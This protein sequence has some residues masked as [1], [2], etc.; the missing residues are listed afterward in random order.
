M[1]FFP[2]ASCLLLMSALSVSCLRTCAQAPCRVDEIRFT[3]VDYDSPCEGGNT[4]IDPVRNHIATGTFAWF[5]IGAPMPASAY[6]FQNQLYFSP[7][8]NED[9]GDYGV[10]FTADTTGCTDTAYAHLDSLVIA[11]YPVILWEEDLCGTVKMKAI[12]FNDT[13]AAHNNYVWLDQFGNYTINSQF[14]T[15]NRTTATV[16]ITNSYGCSEEY[17][18]YLPKSLLQPP[19]ADTVIII[20]GGPAIVC[21]GTQRTYTVAP[22][23]NV[24]YSWTVPAGVVIN[25]GQATPSIAVSFNSS[26]HGGFLK[27]KKTNQCGTTTYSKN[28]VQG[29]SPVRPGTISGIA[30]GLCGVVT[31]YSITNVTGMTY[32]WTLPTGATI[33]NGQGTQVIKVSFPATNFAGVISVTATTNCGTSLARTLSVKSVPGTPTTITG[34]TLVCNGSVGIVYSIAPITYATQYTWTGPTGSRIT[35]NGTTSAANVLT[36]ASPVISVNF[37]KVTTASSIKVQAGNGCGLGVV[38]TLV[39]T[40]CVPRLALSETATMQNILLYPNPI[41]TVTTLRLEMITSS[42]LHFEIMDLEG[43]VWIEKDETAIEGINAYP[44]DLTSLSAGVY[45]VKLKTDQ[46]QKMVRFVKE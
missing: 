2:L 12:N 34:L 10:I 39:L 22:E 15:T 5:R 18:D 1:K 16:K 33:V 32:N 30:A 46:D 17:F 31:T 7:Y 6:V 38:K 3:D 40:P 11:V 43:R 35:A 13:T 23:N 42:Q 4:V 36:T 19:V 8:N 14:I 21:S 25:S 24:T 9:A 27:I 45:I 20:T 26:F 41:S 29:L 28:I 44:L 37:S